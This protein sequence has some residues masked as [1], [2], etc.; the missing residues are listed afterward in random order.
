[1]T[2]E[3]KRLLAAHGWPAQFAYAVN[4]AVRDLMITPS[5]AEA[6]I[7]KYNQ[8]WESAAHEPGLEPAK[9]PT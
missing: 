1:M 8:E 5:E 9:E 7:D 2:E 3:Q 4:A 6:A